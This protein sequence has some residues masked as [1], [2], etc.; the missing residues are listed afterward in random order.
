ML[1]CNDPCT[2]ALSTFIAEQVHVGVDAEY[3]IVR[4]WPL[5]DPAIRWLEDDAL[6][7]LPGG[8]EITAAEVRAGAAPA[9]V[10][11]P[12]DPPAIPS[13]PPPASA[14]TAAPAAPSDLP[15]REAPGATERQ[16]G[17]DGEA[18]GSDRDGGAAA[19]WVAVEVALLVAGG[20][21]AL[22]WK[23]R[24]RRPDAPVLR[25][26]APSANGAD[27]ATASPGVTPPGRNPSG[28]EARRAGN[29]RETGRGAGHRRGSTS[30]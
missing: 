5:D 29:R 11:V 30:P 22:A 26:V 2:D 25:A 23:G 15:A 20:A 7:A 1:F 9:P 14:A 3:E 27:G 18:N 17:R 28:C 12:G 24:R 8:G 6:L 19:R 13:A 4:D 10:A 16:A 21:A